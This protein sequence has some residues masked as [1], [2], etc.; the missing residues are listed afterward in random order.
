[1]AKI[2]H[3]ALDVDGTLVRRDLSLSPAVVRSVEAMRDAGVT[4]SIVTGRSLGEL[5]D[6][7]RSFPWIRYFIV[8]N[9]ATGY[10]AERDAVFY[11]NLLPLSIAKQIEREARSYSVMTQIY[12]DG[13]SYLY[14]DCWENTGRFT[15]EHM[16]HPSLVAGYTPV[17]NIGDL[18]DAR[19]RDIEKLYLTFEDLSDL[20]RIRAF[21]EAF[22]VDLIMSIH[23]GL[24]IT[25][26]GVEK[27]TGLRALCAY[28]GVPQEQ[29]AAVGDGEAD[30]AMFR[31]AGFSIAMEN[32]QAGV[33]AVS[34][35]VAPG[36]D[37]DGAV[38]AIHQILAHT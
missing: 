8:S 25:Q 26:R 22:P 13:T 33:K 7:R 5:I 29:T 38:W 12:A 6:F 23:N 15:Q 20:P 2:M 32:A 16:R 1:M 24:E 34:A 18:L 11:E 37:D 21:C 14:R 31:Q 9:G 10:D 17:E 35:L 27:G 36:N 19:E 3:C 30:I 28:L 4:V